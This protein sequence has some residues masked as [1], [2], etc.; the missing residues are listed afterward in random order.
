MAQ[1]HKVATVEELA[2]DG[3][4]VI[5]EIEG[6]EIAVFH[7]DGEYYALAN[8]CVHQG[9]PLCEG[10]IRGQMTAGAD[11][12]SWEFDEENKVVECPWH[13][14]LFDVTNGRNTANPND[15]TPTYDVEVD[16]GDVLVVR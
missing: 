6:Q 14:W 11:G 2:D 15:R 1:R 4:R 7:L 5:A 16:D 3:S 13:G 12:W 9:G 8:Y 10:K